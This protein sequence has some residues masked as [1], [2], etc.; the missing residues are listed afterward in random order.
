MSNPLESNAVKSWLLEL[1]RH[2]YFPVLV[3]AL[4]ES[5]RLDG[6]EQGSDWMEMKANGYRAGHG[7][8]ILTLRALTTESQPEPKD[9]QTPL[10]FGQDD[11]LADHVTGRFDYE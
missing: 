5:N 4:I 6:W 11:Q 3:D 10:D 2:P 1:G 7:E 8:C 9:Q